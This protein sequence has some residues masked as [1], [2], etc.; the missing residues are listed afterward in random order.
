MTRQQMYIA[1]AKSRMES[2]EVHSIYQ[3]DNLSFDGSQESFDT[4]DNEGY[5]TDSSFIDQVMLD[6]V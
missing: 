6:F 5:S 3:F 4:I 1:A 2:T